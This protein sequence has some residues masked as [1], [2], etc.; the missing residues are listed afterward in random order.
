M[1]GPGQI[2]LGYTQWMLR[3]KAV[4]HVEYFRGMGQKRDDALGRVAEAYDVKPGTI[5]RWASE[6]ST[7][8]KGL[9][10]VW[11]KGYARQAGKITYKL[12]FQDSLSDR[13]KRELDRL[14]RRW[15]DSA[16]ARHGTE[17]QQIPQNK[18]SVVHLPS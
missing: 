16:L 12:K 14:S 4:L 6:I 2:A 17:F 13:D 15:G 7:K 8:L 10:P 18:G 1:V 11:E 5:D 9:R 3:Y